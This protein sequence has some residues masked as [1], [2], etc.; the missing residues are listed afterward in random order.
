MPLERVQSNGRWLA[1]VEV[2]FFSIEGQLRAGPDPPPPPFLARVWVPSSGRTGGGGFRAKS[3]LR[4][5]ISLWEIS[6]SPWIL[7]GNPR[8]SPQCVRPACEKFA[9][10]PEFCVRNF[11]VNLESEISCAKVKCHE[12]PPPPL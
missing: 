8:L 1:N 6:R 5:E 4:W 9:E 10:D 12:N 2:F 7:C 3:N 11:A